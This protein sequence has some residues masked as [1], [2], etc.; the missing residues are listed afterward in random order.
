MAPAV[1]GVTASNGL[2]Y[3]TTTQGLSIY[4]V[5]SLVSVPVTISAV[6]VN[7][8]GSTVVPASSFNIAPDTITAG[9]GVET[10]VWHRAL[11]YGTAALTFTWQTTV[12]GLAAGETRTIAQANG[13]LRQPG[14]FGHNRPAGRG[15]QRRADRGR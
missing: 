13:R 2:L 4:Q 8:S 15:R 5:G 12:S 14:D 9:T 1:H 7:K 3:A 6:L 11:A 10:V